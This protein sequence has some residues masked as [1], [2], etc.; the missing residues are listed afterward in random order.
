MAKIVTAKIC[1]TSE[2]CSHDRQKQL[3]KE[4]KGS[5]LCVHDTAKYKYQCK[6][7]QRVP[8]MPVHNRDKKSR[9]R[10]CGGSQICPHNR[11]KRIT[12][13]SVVTRLK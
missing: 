7:V 4:C 3:C 1:G 9:C 11:R 13:R 10:E 8:N 5:H 12:V 6:E 2:I